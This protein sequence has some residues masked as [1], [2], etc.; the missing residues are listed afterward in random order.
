MRKA[1]SLGSALL[2]LTA[3]PWLLCTFFFTPLHFTY[4][5]DKAAAQERERGRSAVGVGL[6]TWLGDG[7]GQSQELELGRRVKQGREGAAGGAEVREED[8]EGLLRH[9]VCE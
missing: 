3:V 5:R 7:A 9:G 2:V 8:S 1:R 6:G 4:G